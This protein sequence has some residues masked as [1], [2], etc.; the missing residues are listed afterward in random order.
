MLY[1][2]TIYNSAT[3]IVLFDLINKRMDNKILSPTEQRD[4][5]DNAIRQEWMAEKDNGTPASVLI[6]R[7]AAN[8]GVT[9]NTAYNAIKQAGLI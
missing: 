5:R 2:Q 9:H 6:T 1:L 7:I 8:H 4:I 3:N